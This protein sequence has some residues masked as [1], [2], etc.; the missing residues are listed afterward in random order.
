MR[1]GLA[2]VAVLASSARVARADAA[3]PPT[4]STGADETPVSPALQKLFEVS[5][6]ILLSADQVTEPGLGLA[7][8][9]RKALD[10][11]LRAL[12]FV[13]GELGYNSVGEL[14][15]AAMF[16]VT[17]RLAPFVRLEASIGYDGIGFGIERM[18]TNVVVDDNLLYGA[19]AALEGRT[20]TLSFGFYGRNDDV[21]SY[22]L[23][24]ELDYY[25]S[26]GWMLFAR[27]TSY[28]D[29]CTLFSLGVSP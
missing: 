29:T 17:A 16:G 24:A 11:D 9:V 3:P 18:S 2:V 7:I 4:R 5:G 8:G 1:S 28:E 23:R 26:G 19:L 10:L 13:R 21:V 15:G 27:L 14:F 20:T 22:E 25:T 6:Q 12:P